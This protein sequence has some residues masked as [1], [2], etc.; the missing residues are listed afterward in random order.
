MNQRTLMFCLCAAVFGAACSDTSRTTAP[1]L[2][3]PTT[4]ASA[5]GS[6][7]AVDK[8]VAI[9]TSISM[10]WAS[11]GVFAGSQ[12][13]SWPAMMRFAGSG[14]ITLPLI[15]SPGCT[16]PLIAPLG[17][18]RRLSG[19][20]FAGST[21]C[22]PNVAGVQL[23][24]Q[25]V[26]LAGALTIDALQTTPEAVAA[27]MPWFGRVLPLHTTQVTAALAQHPDLVSIELGGNDILGATSGLIVPF[28]T[29]VP[30]PVFAAAFNAVL[31]VVGAA[32][33][34]GVVFGMPSDGRNLPSLRR[35]DEIWADAAE[36]A[37]LH[38]NVSPNCNGSQNWINVSVKSL[39]L[40][41]TA[42]ATSTPQLFSCADIP[43]TVDYVLTPSDVAMLNGTLAQMAAHAKQQAD[44][45]GYAFVS[46]GA[47][48][49]RAD[50]KPPVYSVISQLTSQ[51]PYGNYIS[52]DGVHP[53]PLGSAVLAQAAAKAINKTY[54]GAAAHLPDIDDAETSIADQLQE[55]VTASMALEL[56]KRVVMERKGDRVPTCPMPG[57]CFI[58]GRLTPR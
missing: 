5:N 11:N 47:L 24:T 40:V 33:P 54:P 22:A 25:N 32:V 52:L 56:A 43:G 26:A 53:G 27:T 17:L 36:F 19:E 45:H 35:G 57:G 49:D 13:T 18:G 39:V 37:A 29:V 14:Q 21:V 38:V 48:Y 16:S 7:N 55:P 51:F 2:K 44:A 10:G 34:R 4:A 50:L 58:T 12:L 41:F 8:F 1:E 9:G 31:N 30:F 3:S 46:L 28:Q 23:P 6:P 15:Q 42:A 20:S